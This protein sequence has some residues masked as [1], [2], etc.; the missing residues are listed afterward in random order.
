MCCV[1]Q[2]MSKKKSGRVI[3][4]SSVVG[5]T[6]NVG[7]VNYAAAKAGVIGMTKTVAREYAGR[8]ITCNAIAPGFI[9]S[10]M[11]GELS[12]KIV[13][14]IMGTIP[15]KRFGEPEEVSAE[16]VTPGVCTRVYSEGVIYQGLRGSR[17]DGV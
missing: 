8:G 10:D 17:S 4:I 6:G 5:V 11:T 9:R 14:A 1:A 15:M 16:R 12:E 3:N 7:Q 13:E 2:V